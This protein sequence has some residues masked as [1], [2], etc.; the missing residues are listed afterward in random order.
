MPWWLISFLVVDV[1]RFVVTF[2]SN[3]SDR[4][5][6]LR[7]ATFG[8]M[9]RLIPNAHRG[10]FRAAGVDRPLIF[11]ARKRMGILA[12]LSSAS[13]PDQSRSSRLFERFNR[14]W[15]LLALVD[16]LRG[17]IRQNAVNFDE[18]KP[19]LAALA[20]LGGYVLVLA[21]LAKPFAIS[22]LSPPMWNYVVRRGLNI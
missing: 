7:K 2:G 11:L 19:L 3:R 5:A 21:P 9:A 15:R 22:F 18:P 17:C 16:A 8:R 14:A 10:S 1:M 12:H 13:A 6:A 20:L 4:C